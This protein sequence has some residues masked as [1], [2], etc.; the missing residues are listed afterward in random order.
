MRIADCDWLDGWIHLPVRALQ[1]SLL[2][3]SCLGQVNSLCDLMHQ[4]HSFEFMRG[5]VFV[6]NYAV[7]RQY[8]GQRSGAK[9]WIQVTHARSVVQ[10][11]AAN[12][13]CKSRASKASKL[14]IVN[15]FELFS[16]H[17]GKLNFASKTAVVVKSAVAACKNGHF[18]W[19]R[20]IKRLGAVLI[21][22]GHFS[23]AA[24]P[25]GQSGPI[26]RSPLVPRARGWKLVPLGLLQLLLSWGWE[27]RRGSAQW[28]NLAHIY[29]I[30]L[31]RVTARYI[32]INS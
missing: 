22:A 25:F 11:V 2:C 19:S 10:F 31:R 23:I 24:R 15:E 18:T 21:Y 28:M 6:W 8:D 13:G 30:W 29:Y 27:V 9:E 20:A 5:I 1:T 16:L 26:L 14:Q 4:L 17:H 32:S 3:Q 12:R 7:C